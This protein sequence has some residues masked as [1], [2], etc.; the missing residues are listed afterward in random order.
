MTVTFQPS[1]AQGEIAA[2]PSKSMAHRLLICAGLAEGESV[3]SNADPS[4]DILATVDCLNKLG[5]YARY[6]EKE[7]AVTVRGTDLRNVF[8]GAVLNCRE[9]GS[10]LRFFIPLCLLNGG[11]YVLTGS[12]RLFNRPLSV[13]ETICRAQGLR[14]EQNGNRLT[15]SGKLKSGEYEV[16]GNVSSQFISGLLF[17]LPLLDGD[18]KIKIIPPI[19]S[20]PYILMT[21]Q[22]LEVFGVKADFED[23]TT[24]TVKGNSRYTAKN[25]TVE[26]DFS[27]AAF[28]DAFN[29][30]G[31]TVSVSGL[32][33][34]SLQGDKIYRRYFRLLKSGFSE[35][36]VSDCPDLAP[37]LMAI[38]AVLNGAKL[39]GTKRLKIKESDRGAAMAEE[40]SK[41]GVSTVLK[42]NEITVY[43]GAEAPKEMLYGHNDHRI[44]MAL[45]VLL[46]KLGGKV[47]GAEAVKKS[48][49]DFFDRLRTVGIQLSKDVLL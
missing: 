48:F 19:E 15:V 2:P 42:E 45:S 11:A 18:S 26:G 1:V 8:E 34:N 33:E 4:E 14:F 24:V 40:L 32:S 3:I 10:T 37:V 25:V 5:A 29:V 31:G 39:T 44:V 35:I 17:A 30:I 13:Y 46:S 20:K 28:F 43:P 9:C 23:E 41:C 27:N 16:A 12:E 6:C 22:A 38:A 7:R 36:D 47:E 21:M 49:P